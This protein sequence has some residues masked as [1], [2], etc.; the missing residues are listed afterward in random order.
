M[1]VLKVREIVIFSYQFI[2]TLAIL[3]HS[4]IVMTTAHCSFEDSMYS[5]EGNM[6]SYIC[7]AFFD[8]HSIF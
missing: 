8:L 2:L 1:C 6:Y 4:G 5:F 3:I 7:R